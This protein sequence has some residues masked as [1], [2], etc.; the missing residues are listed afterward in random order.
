[1][2]SKYHP[3][4]D[5]S[6]EFRH[7]TYIRVG[8]YGTEDREY[9]RSATNGKFYV[10]G[11]KLGMDTV[12]ELYEVLNREWIEEENKLTEKGEEMKE[13][14]KRDKVTVK[15]EL[16]AEKTELD[17]KIEKL[18]RFTLSIAMTELSRNQ[19]I[20]M[21]KQLSAMETYSLAL[22]DRILDITNQE[23]E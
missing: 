16:T 13:P 19:T 2:S 5:M 4:Q 10:Y 17:N 21:Y 14:V 22:R 9:Y 18:K 7:K 12:K 11:R 23:D 6:Y 15:H 8:P 20:A 3:H 1:M